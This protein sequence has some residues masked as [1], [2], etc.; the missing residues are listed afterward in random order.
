MHIIDRI[1]IIPS[2]WLEALNPFITWFTLH[3]EDQLV[4]CIFKRNPSL[5]SDL[6]KIHK[7]LSNYTLLE[8]NKIKNEEEQLQIVELMGTSLISEEVYYIGFLPLQSYIDK[9]KQ[10]NHGP[11]CPPEKE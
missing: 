9:K 7:L 1:S 8:T 11:K 10:I 3:R 6:A 4:D 5:Q 2:P